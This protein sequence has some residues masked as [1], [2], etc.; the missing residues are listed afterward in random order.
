MYQLF[1]GARAVVFLFDSVAECYCRAFPGAI[2]ETKIHIIPNGYDGTIEPFVVPNATKCTILYSGTIATYRYD[3]LLRSL[4]LLKESDPAKARTLRL[5]F[6][7]DSMED[8][9]TKVAALKL[10]DIV[11]ITG[12]TS[13]AEIIRLQREAHALLVLGRS[14]TMRG[15]ELL[16]GAKLFAYL[17]AGRPIFGVLPQDETTK[18][19]HHVNVSTVANVE[20]LPEIIFTLRK[21]WDAW[22][23]G[24]LSSLLPDPV[25]CELYSAE[26][27]T[28]AL[29]R[30]LK[31]LP[32]AA[33]FVPGSTEI[34]LSLR[35][36][37][38]SNP[39]PVKW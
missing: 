11:D 3:T 2:D 35:E 7:G 33:R 12:P 17:K 20:S 22:S 32:P 18:I 27:Q 9:A 21:L 23:N 37:I 28:K 16:A 31:G 15:Y 39:V 24:K 8:L 30:A 25:K 6:V 38:I 4:V 10:S 13:Q 14:S 5:H 36:E 1:K 34:P 26:R 29:V 19:L